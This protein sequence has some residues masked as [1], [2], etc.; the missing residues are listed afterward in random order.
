MQHAS[1][2][3]KKVQLK[4]NDRTYIIFEKLENIYST[5]NKNTP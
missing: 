4:K 1:N 3:N 2:I 5:T